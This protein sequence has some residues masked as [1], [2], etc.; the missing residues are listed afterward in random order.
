MYLFDWTFS[1]ICSVAMEISPD[2]KLDLRN[3]NDDVINTLGTLKQKALQFPEKYIIPVCEMLNNIFSCETRIKRSGAVFQEL[4]HHLFYQEMLSNESVISN[5]KLTVVILQSLNLFIQAFPRDLVDSTLCTK[6]FIAPLLSLFQTCT[7][8]MVMESITSLLCLLFSLLCNCKNGPK[9]AYECDA[10]IALAKA[11]TKSLTISTAEELLG[12]FLCQ[13]KLYNKNNTAD[14]L[15]DALLHKAIVDVAKKFAHFQCQKFNGQYSQCILTITADEEF[16]KKLVSLNYMDDLICLISDDNCASIFKASLHAQGNL[17]ICQADVKMKL[18]NEHKL[19]HRIVSYIREHSIDGDAGTLSAYCRMLHVLASDDRTRR[20]L[21]DIGSIEVLLRLLKLQSDNSEICCQSLSILCSMVSTAPCNRHPFICK[22]VIKVICGIIRGSST[23]K[24]KEHAFQILV[25]ICERDD[26]ACLVRSSGILE[27]LVNIIAASSN[28]DLH[29]WGLILSEKLS[30]YTVAFLDMSGDQQKDSPDSGIQGISCAVEENGDFPSHGTDNLQHRSAKVDPRIKACVATKMADDAFCVGRIFGST[31]GTCDNCE[32]DDISAELV[33]RVHDMSPMQYQHLIDNGW[34]RIGGV[35]MFRLRENHS[36][37]CCDWEARVD[38][39]NFDH[40]KSQHFCKVLRK[41]PSNISSKI[42]PAY[43]NK[44]AFDL[45]NSY[46]VSRHNKPL[47]SEHT[48]AEYVVYS[49]Y[50]Q[51]EGKGGI[52]YGTYHMEHYLGDKLVA[53]CVIDVVPYGVV[54]NYMWYD[55]CR[56]INKYSFGVYSILKAI[57]HVRSLATRNPDIRYLYLKKWNPQNKKLSY[58]ANYTPADYFCPCISTEW[59]PNIS[60]I[61]ECIERKLS[62]KST[63]IANKESIANRTPISPFN[64]APMNAYDVGVTPYEAHNGPID[65]NTMP[66]CLQF[67]NADTHSFTTLGE[68]ITLYQIKEYQVQIMKKRY[69]E[70][71]V[72]LGQPLSKQFYIILKVCQQ[73]FE[74]SV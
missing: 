27:D 25:F 1:N 53:V 36:I 4:D 56:E 60:G 19:H 70:L 43:F 12:I 58:K 72:A 32:L 6:S 68:A 71:I 37:K 5:P 66:V 62:M 31:Y 15:I 17:A 7:D 51:Q 63:K 67:S 29:R 33:M 52:V 39:L 61:N 48:Y 44:D 38:A 8:S 74:T 11:F 28:D 59:V 73:A 13:F 65:I 55:N 45:Y 22:N 42:L 49:P 24:A 26:G 16:S 64:P 14:T 47:A 30:L 20:Y 69:K 41:M 57:E 9:V 18:I 10:H 46:N 35:K 23:D 2:V 21:Y 34:Y 50:G 3:E 40:T 54:G